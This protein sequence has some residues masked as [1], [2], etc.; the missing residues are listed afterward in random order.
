MAG[1]DVLKRNELRGGPADG[2]RERS[3]L[4]VP[5]WSRDPHKGSADLTMSARS[6][7]SKFDLI[8]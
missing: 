2:G 5:D 3:A 1:A 8:N 4:L 7:G 6:F